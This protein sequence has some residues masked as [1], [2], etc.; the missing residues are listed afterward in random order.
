L[1][2]LIELENVTVRR[3]E[4]V[5]LDSVTLSPLS[6]PS[7]VSIFSTVFSASSSASPRL[8]VK[9]NLAKRDTADD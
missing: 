1:P 7:W 5:A 4:R 3:D 2:P 6:P 8:R 9:T